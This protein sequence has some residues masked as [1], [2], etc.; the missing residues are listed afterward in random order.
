MIVVTGGNG[1]LGRA[2]VTALRKRIDPAN[3]VV[4]V[5]D[6]DKAADLA[7]EGIAIRG[8]ADY[9]D[10]DSM[11]RAFDGARTALIISGS[12]PVEV[13]K[14]QQ[15]N[16]IDGAK[17]AGVQ[18]IVYTSV[19]DA[20]APNSPFSFTDVHRDTEAYLA[21]SG[22]AYTIARNTAYAEL[23]LLFAKGA[24]ATGKLSIPTGDGRVAF[25][26]RTDLANALAAI[27]ATD[28]YGERIYT[29]T[30]SVAYSYD[31]V[32]AALSEAVGR[33]IPHDDCSP[34]TYAAGLSVA[35]LPPFL[36]E[37]MVGM[38]E[39]VRQGM[40]AG[41]TQDIPLLTG[42]PAVDGLTILR[43]VAPTLILPA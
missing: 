42:Q 11:A 22:V 13:R 20:A 24:L 3:F 36:V 15:R 6:A 8:N 4:S 41:V 32:A 35:G 16:A 9:S 12:S 19:Q 29:L 33:T 27:I 37:G 30:G 23:N 26:T 5:R 38:A 1:Q 17:R 25:A 39:A 2:V 10:S 14:Q 7:T 21:D 18:R 28:D 40:Y 31:D 43:R 34:E